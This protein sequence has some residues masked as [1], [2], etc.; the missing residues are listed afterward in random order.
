[1]RRWCRG[2]CGGGRRDA[3]AASI[4]TQLAGLTQPVELCDAS[5]RVLG[6]FVPR[7]DL[8]EWEPISPDISEAELER[9][10]KSNEPRYTTKEVL[11]RLENPA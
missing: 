8:S 3:V 7:I 4:S 2:T 11:A 10:A 1:M 9:R 5:G 6:Q